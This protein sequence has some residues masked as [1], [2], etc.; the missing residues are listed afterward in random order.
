MFKL[1]ICTKKLFIKE[2]YVIQVLR[3]VTQ[4]TSTLEFETFS[5]MLPMVV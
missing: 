4:K 1:M 2:Y 5:L 3:P